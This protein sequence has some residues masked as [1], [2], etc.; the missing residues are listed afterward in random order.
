MVFPP[1]DVLYLTSIS[2]ITLLEI[3]RPTQEKPHVCGI[4]MY[5]FDQKVNLDRHIN[6]VHQGSDIYRCEEC[7]APFNGQLQLAAHLRAIH[8]KR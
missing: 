7:N 3:L 5:S 1:S 4:C 2:I 6:T 8:N